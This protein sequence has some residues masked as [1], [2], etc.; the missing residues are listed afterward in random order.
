MGKLKCLEL[1]GFVEVLS[2]CEESRCKIK[3]VSTSTKC[4]KSAEC[5]L[6]SKQFFFNFI[7]TNEVY[8][9]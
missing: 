6:V 1:R 7:K 4:V 3:R 2:I 8:F 5:D 9:N